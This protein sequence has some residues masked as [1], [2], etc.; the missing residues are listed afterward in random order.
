[1]SAQ[2]DPAAARAAE[3]GGGRYR[4]QS[5]D[6]DAATERAWFQKWRDMDPVD[7]LDLAVRNSIAARELCEEGVRAQWP[8]AG[9][10][11]I[12]TE[13]LRRCYGDEYVRRMHPGARWLRP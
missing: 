10:E 4:T 8:E 5:L 1:M 2:P 11:E 12:R 3:P 9:E 13:V 7:K 6:V